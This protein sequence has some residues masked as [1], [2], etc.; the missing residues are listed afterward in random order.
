ME[1]E[2]V[3]EAIRDLTDRETI[4]DLAVRYAHCVWRRDVE[5][6]ISLFAEG[7]SMELEGRPPIVG[8]EALAASYQDLLRGEFMPFVHNHVIEL[9]GDRAWGVCYLDLRATV[10][11]KPMIGAGVYD[12]EYVREDGQWKFARRRLRMS[13]F[14][15]ITEG[16]TPAQEGP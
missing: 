13:H 14:V 15:P 8:R 6:A 4:R 12:D 16:W 5:G 11:G 7:A 3:R 9:D 1:T 10:D 2:D